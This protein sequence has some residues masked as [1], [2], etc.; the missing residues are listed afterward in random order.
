M[1][2]FVSI[3]IPAFNAERFISYAISSILKQTY[4]AY[5]IIIIDDCSTDDTYKILK[6]CDTGE[7][8][9][10]LLKTAKNSKQAVA[11]NLGLKYANGDYIAFLDAD[12]QWLPHHLEKCVE[13]LS[14]S[15][16]DIVYCGFFDSYS[17]DDMENDSHMKPHSVTFDEFHGESGI[18]SFIEKN[19]IPTSTVVMKRGVVNTVG[20]FDQLATPAEDYDYWLRSLLFGHIITYVPMQT[21][22]YR[23]HSASSTTNNSTRWSFNEVFYVIDKNFKLSGL[24]QRPENVK[25]SLIIRL[26]NWIKNS[27]ESTDKIKKIRYFIKFGFVNI[28]IK[29]LL[30]IFLY[31]IGIFSKDRFDSSL[32]A[33]LTKSIKG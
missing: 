19:R 22:I 14:E 28:N 24:R 30:I 1:N 21:M 9:L 3:I 16:A 25:K 32:T 13:K 29:L 6:T 4:Q 31:I 20:L 26:K 7:K 2:K 17:S 12:D 11:R 5:E 23:H 8:P 15:G 33:R 10:R 18:N 27:Q